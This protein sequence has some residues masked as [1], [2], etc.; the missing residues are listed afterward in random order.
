MTQTKEIKSEIYFLN[1]SNKTDICKHL[2]V[3]Q[4]SIRREQ[5]PIVEP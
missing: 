2:S 1:E 4:C 5:L 3:Y